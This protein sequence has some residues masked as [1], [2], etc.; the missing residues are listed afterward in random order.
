MAFKLCVKVD[1]TLGGLR[2]L[3]E[4]FTDT[5][6]IQLL[7]PVLDVSKFKILPHRNIILHAS[8]AAY[9]LSDV[10]DDRTKISYIENMMRQLT[11]YGD[12][13]TVLF[14]VGW[15]KGD[16]TTE[17]VVEFLRHLVW[18]YDVNILLENTIVVGSHDRAVEVCNTVDSNRVNYCLDIAHVRA[19]LNQGVDVQE[20]YKGLSKVKHIH[21]S[22]TSNGDGYKDMPTHGVNHPSLREVKQDLNVLKQFNISD[23]TLC[24]EVSE[25]DYA[26]RLNQ[27]QEIKLL[28][29]GGVV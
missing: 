20:Y 4:Y 10:A 14:H 27:I 17:R 6:E 18:L 3:Q 2:Q 21:F 29:K 16:A 1:E 12:K 9:S 13:Y 26:C 19:V 8:P 23:C 22:Y 15:D 5:I 28:K 7:N 11:H 24:P 25:T